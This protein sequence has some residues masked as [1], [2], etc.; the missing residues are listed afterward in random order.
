MWLN[1]IFAHFPLHKSDIIGAK[2]PQRFGLSNE[3]V[4]SRERADGCG[5]MGWKSHQRD[6]SLRNLVCAAKSSMERKVVKSCFPHHGQT[7]TLIWLLIKGPE[8]NPRALD[9]TAADKSVRDSELSFPRAINLALQFLLE[10]FWHWQG[11]INKRPPNGWPSA[12]RTM[13]KVIPRGGSEKWPAWTVE[14]IPFPKVN[15]LRNAYL[16]L[17]FCEISSLGS[18]F[19]SRFLSLLEIWFKIL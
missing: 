7:Q 1:V 16:S 9:E 8:F 18:P 12:A 2:S 13:H 11:L 15:R 6:F 5:Q 14:E 10:A 3:T 19:D 4:Q 17:G